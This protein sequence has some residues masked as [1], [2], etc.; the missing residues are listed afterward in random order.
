M[1]Y[2]LISSI[3]FTLDKYQTIKKSMMHAFAAF[4][5]NIARAFVCMRKQ[6][7]NAYNYLLKFLLVHEPSFLYN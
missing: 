7:L 1:I 3:N 2:L 4:T 5:F 6:R